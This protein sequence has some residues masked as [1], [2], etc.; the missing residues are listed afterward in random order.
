MSANRHPERDATHYADTPGPLP[1][2][3]NEHAQSGTPSTR[4]V[5]WPTSTTDEL[6]GTL[7]HLI[8][9]IDDVFG[10]TTRRDLS[11]RAG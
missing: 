6:A 1:S 11:A 2:S 7:D 10:F 5:V 8:H 4:T 3:G 9:E